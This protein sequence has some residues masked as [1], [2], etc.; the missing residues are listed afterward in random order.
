MNV[1][2]SHIMNDA[3][4]ANNVENKLIIIKG[5]DHGFRGANAER[6]TTA[7]VEWFAAHLAEAQK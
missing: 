7:M 5:A 3:L 1:G 6:A 2:N 4:Q